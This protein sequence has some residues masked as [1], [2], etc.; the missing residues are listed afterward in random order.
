MGDPVTLA[1]AGGTAGA[2]MSPKDPLKGALLGAAGGYGGGALLGSAAVGGSS[3]AGAGLA[4]SANAFLPG[5]QGGM[6]ALGGGGTTALTG[7]TT[8]PG[9]LSGTMAGLSKDFG[10]I[11]KFAQQNPVL[12]GMAMN[13]GM[14]AMQ[15]AP[16]L[17]SGGMIQA[18]GGQQE[19]YP[20][21]PMQP[22]MPQ[23]KI[24]LL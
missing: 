16:Q 20:Q 3:A 12:A 18:R 15:P 19:E 5:V 8:T 21:M 2:M 22:F 9:I 24:S 4:G 23:R 14:N 13:T 17:P 6:G 11:G 10:G 1:V 7:A